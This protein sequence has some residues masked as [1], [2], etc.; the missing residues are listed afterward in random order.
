[1]PWSHV[2]RPS[3][4]EIKSWK[5][6]WLRKYMLVHPGRILKNYEYFAWIDK[7]RRVYLKEH[8]MSEHDPRAVGQH[9]TNWLD[10][11]AECEEEV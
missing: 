2:K 3:D 11:N 4:D 8:N 7:M 5:S 6:P 10:N 1:M 9:F